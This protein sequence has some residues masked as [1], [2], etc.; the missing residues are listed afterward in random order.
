MAH[1]RQLSPTV[2]LD[3]MKIIYRPMLI[4]VRSEQ[5]KLNVFFRLKTAVNYSTVKRQV[6]AEVLRFK[7]FYLEGFLFRS[8]RLTYK[9]VYTCIVV[10]SSEEDASENMKYLSAP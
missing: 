8:Q 1:E 2:Y 5:E 6:G 4:L 10:I 9:I 7:A 3:K